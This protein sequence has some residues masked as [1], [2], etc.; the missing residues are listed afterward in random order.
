MKFF[1]EL[2][3]FLRNVRETNFHETFHEIFSFPLAEIAI[4][5]IPFS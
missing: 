3:S 4:R 2:P 5:E 1:M